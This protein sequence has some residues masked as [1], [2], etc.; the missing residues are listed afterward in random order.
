MN[1]DMNK[2]RYERVQATYI[3]RYKLRYS[4][5][6]YSVCQTQ[7]VSQGGALFLTDRIFSEGQEL[8]M[9]IQFPFASE[10]V[11]VIAEIVACKKKMNNVYET[12]VKFIDMN[13]FVT[14]KLGELIKRRK[15]TD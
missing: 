14:K 15:E 11:K 13:S 7:N 10:Q 1:N 9:N 2:R 6:N 8:E 3:V 4:G 12:R 5:M